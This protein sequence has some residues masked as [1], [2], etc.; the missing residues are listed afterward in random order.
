MIGCVTGFC[1]TL[2]AGRFVASWHAYAASNKLA[3]M[4]DMSTY[5]DRDWDCDLAIW[6][7]VHEGDILH[8]IAD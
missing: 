7:T 4:T 3:N 6:R 8:N 2:Q 5:L 1:S